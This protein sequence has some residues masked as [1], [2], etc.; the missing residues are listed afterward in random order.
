MLSYMRENAGS[1]IIK[2]L[3]GI[4]VVVFVFFYGFSD[5]QKTDTDAVIARVGDREIT[6][7]QYQTAYKNTMEMYRSLYKNQLND[8]LMERL[9]LK[10]KVLDDLINRELLLQEAE[11]RTIRVTE[12][13]VQASI[14]GMPAFQ[15]NGRFSQALYQ[16]ALNYYGI[17]AADFEKDKEREL[18]LRAMESIITLSAKVSDR[19][20][21]DRYSMQK[22]KVKIGYV[23]ID[24]DTLHRIMP[25]HFFAHQKLE[26]SPESH[27]MP[28][29]GSGAKVFVLE[30]NQVF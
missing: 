24:P 27:R 17:S 3:F 23:C 6:Q 16:R 14:M 7:A 11:R 15:E 8:E 26:K 4:I 13:E 30:V 5:L 28:G 20:V 12:A 10:Q 21:R 18:M 2:V 19:E 22:E 25:D 9:G 29:P 1:W